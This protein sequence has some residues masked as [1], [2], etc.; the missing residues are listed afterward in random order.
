[1]SSQRTAVPHCP[2]SLP[3]EGRHRPAGSAETEKRGAAACVR[4]ADPPPANPRA[5][6]VPPFSPRARRLARAPGAKSPPRD[7][8]AAPRRRAPL[9]SPLGPLAPA[10]A[11]A[12]APAR[13]RRL[14]AGGESVS[15]AARRALP[16]GRRFLPASPSRF[17]ARG[18]PPRTQ[19]RDRRASGPSG[20]PGEEMNR[21]TER[22]GADQPIQT[23]HR[24]PEAAP[25][26]AARARGLGNA[27][28]APCLLRAPR[29]Q[30]VAAPPP[31]VRTG[32][33]VLPA[34][35]P[36]EC[37]RSYQRSLQEFKC[38]PATTDYCSLRQDSVSLT[39]GSSSS[40]SSSAPVDRIGCT[41]P[42]R[43]VA[44]QLAGGI[45][46]QIRTAR[47]DKPQRRRSASSLK[48]G[49]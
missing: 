5:P 38:Q 23:D 47:R 32:P 49:S 44:Y 14:C 19:T 18:R 10:A 15:P 22:N 30:P 4:G 45:P 46:R 48:S 25:P 36:D 7:S 39:A 2:H 41:V 31:A 24:P 28:A 13:S 11:A 12:L 6:A 16:P 1:L 43:C 9:A 35:V 33:A 34:G 8:C 29:F 20:G 17:E 42:K 40:S 21:G 3:G 26:L 27:T 37:T